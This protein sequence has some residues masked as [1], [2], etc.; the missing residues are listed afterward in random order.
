MLRVI[1]S[2]PST[3]GGATGD[4]ASHSVQQRPRLEE[5]E[6]PRVRLD[7]VDAHGGVAVEIRGLSTDERAELA[8]ARARRRS[9]EVQEQR[10]L[11]VVLASSTRRGRVVPVRDVPGLEVALAPVVERELGDLGH[12]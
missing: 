7:V 8:A 2:T 1:P 9:V 10:H 6:A 5:H 11:A 12:E 3:R 4:A